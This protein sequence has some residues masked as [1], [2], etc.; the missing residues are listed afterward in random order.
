MPY[1]R[2][3]DVKVPGGPVPEEALPHWQS[4]G[5]DAIDDDDAEKA[6][7]KAEADARTTTTSRS[8]KKG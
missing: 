5:W 1:I 3:P 7:A 6:V 2:H 4:L 8:A